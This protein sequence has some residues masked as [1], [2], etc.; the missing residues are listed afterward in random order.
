M[1]CSRQKAVIFKVNIHTQL[2]NIFDLRTSKLHL[3]TFETNISG[4]CDKQHPKK[5]QELSEVGKSHR[6]K[7]FQTANC[8][9]TSKVPKP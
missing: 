8:I 5:L 7:N 2:I 4:E 3:S 9:N 6:R 1:T